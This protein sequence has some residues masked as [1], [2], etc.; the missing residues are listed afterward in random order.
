MVL[1]LLIR[2]AQA[3]GVMLVVAAAAFALLR[4]TG[5]PVVNMVGQEAG[6][7]ERE[8]LR[9]ALGLN[10]PVVVQFGRFLGNALQG[11]FGVSYRLQQPVAELLADRAPATLELVLVSALLAILLGV[12]LGLWTGIKPDSWLS[13]AILTISLAGVSLPTFVIGILLIYVFAVELAWLP[14]FGRGGVVDLGPWQTGLLTA[15]GWR[16]L[17]LPAVTLSLFQMT[18][19]L[20]LV[21]AEMLEVLRSDFIRFARARGLSARSLYLS[22]A[23][24]NTLLP[25]I[26][27]IGLNI[28]SLIAFSIVTE[29]VFQWP[30]LGSLFL[31]AVAFADVPVMAAYLVLVALV[32]VLINLLVDLTY[33]AIDPRLRRQTAGRSGAA[34]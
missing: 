20:R 24:R 29:T 19:I 8:A 3:L 28:G 17:I 22:H 11:D 23:L 5:D 7:E 13:R 16:S 26:T 31:Q 12:P 2:A 9:E 32:F 15:E 25:V 27:V 1:T 21:R 18:L 6:L 33:L 30:G 4:F 14:S 34:S 10:D